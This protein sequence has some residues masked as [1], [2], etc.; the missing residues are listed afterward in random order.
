MSPI[1]ETIFELFEK[2]RSPIMELDFFT[3]RSK[4]GTVLVFIPVILSKSAVFFI[5]IL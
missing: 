1:L 5:N 3:F 4:T 2:D